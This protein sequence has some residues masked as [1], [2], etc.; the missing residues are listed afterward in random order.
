MLVFC[1]IYDATREGGSHRFIYKEQQP[2]LQLH[3]TI[4]EIDIVIQTKTFVG[5]AE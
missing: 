4:E 2:H 1:T 3:L 5:A